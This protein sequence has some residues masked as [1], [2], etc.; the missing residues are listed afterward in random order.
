MRVC[1]CVC[2]CVRVRV[3]DAGSVDQKSPF[4]PPPASVRV[5]AHFAV[6]GDDGEAA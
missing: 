1:I 3:G 4:L 5:C 6:L 2:V